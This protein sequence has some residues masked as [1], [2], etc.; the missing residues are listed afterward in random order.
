MIDFSKPSISKSEINEVVKVLK[1]G[2]LTTGSINRIFSEKINA[3]IGS[4]YCIP[5]SSCTAALHLALICAGIKKG[6][7]VITTPFTFTATLNTI[8]YLGAKPVL[9]DIKKN[10]FIIDEDLIERSITKRTKAIIP[11]HYAGFS[12]D[13]DKLTRLCKK[14]NLQLIEDAAHAFGSKYKNNFIGQ[15]S[16]FCCF[17]FYPTK[18]ITT[19]EGGALVTNSEEV[20]KQAQTLALHG[21]TRTAWNRYAK[22]GSWKYDVSQLGYKYN[23]P[24]INCALGIAQLKRFSE[25]QK[26][27]ELLY[28]VFKKELGAFDSIK[29]MTGNTY[30][31]PFRHLFVIRILNDKVS[32]DTIIE[33]LKKKNIICSVHFIPVYKFTLYKKMFKSAEKKFPNTESVFSNCISLPFSS[34]ITAS[35]GRFVSK[36]LTNL[37]KSHA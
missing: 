10:D 17:S 28:D 31:K 34:A 7:E 36:E 8:R 2:W 25:L 15:K 26:K 23:L 14:Y 4:K 35:Q 18:N 29:I 1:S 33:G 21:I 12:A 13:L 22:S 16:K 6:D 11:V 32:R 37:L 5:V 9:V 20:Y 3:L 24:D 19:I 27:R 30:T